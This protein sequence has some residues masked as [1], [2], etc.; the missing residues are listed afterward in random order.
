M[1]SR[2][3]TMSRGGSRF[4]YSLDN[5]DTKF[6]GVTSIVGMLPKQQFLAPWSARLTAELAVDSI[7]YI[8][9]MAARD[10]QGAIDY[11]KNASRRYTNARSDVGSKAHDL[12]ERILRGE[13]V[14]RVHP[15]LEPYRKH[16]EEF[17]AAVNPELVSA[18]NVAWS[19]EFEY[20]GSYDAALRVWLDDDGYPTPDHSGTPR[21]VIADWKTS[22]RTYPEVALQM[23]A[24]AN[25]EL[26][27][28]PDGTSEEMPTFDGAFVLHITGTEWEF[29]P[30]HIGPEVFDHFLSLRHTF[31][32][33]RNVSNTVLGSPVAQSDRITTGTQRRA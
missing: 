1:A 19:E 30:V 3:R 33:Q 23:A 7:D 13:H 24:Y 22:A 17:I 15:D 11:L 26:V 6:P 2:V 20:A 29:V 14:G 9:D 10:R 8:G 16:F 5:P 18:E 32:W 25:A 4:Y 27:I 12:F 31:E 21:L 28:Y